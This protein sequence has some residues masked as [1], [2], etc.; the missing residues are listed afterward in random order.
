MTGRAKSTKNKTPIPAT[1]VGPA[2]DCESDFMVNPTIR[3]IEIQCAGVR[4]G[5]HQT[6]GNNRQLQA[7]KTRSHQR[8]W[9]RGS[10]VSSIIPAERFNKL[11]TILIDC[12]DVSKSTVSC[13]PMIGR[14]NSLL[15]PN[16]RLLS[17]APFDP[18]G[19]AVCLVHDDTVR[20]IASVDPD[21]SHWL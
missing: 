20:T 17:S 19:M 12:V 9:K 8:L 18:L 4:F 14:V 13:G 6:G 5:T 3:P 1:H 15:T 16:A 7:E 10:C 2:I 11:F 21:H